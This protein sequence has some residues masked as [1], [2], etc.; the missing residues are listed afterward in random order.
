M[1]ATSSERRSPADARGFTLPE[2]IALLVVIG[3]LAA[4]A[5]PKL[6]LG[7]PLRDEAWRDEVLAALRL[8][9]QTAVSHRRLVCVE[10]ATDRVALRIAATHPASACTTALRGPDGGDDF[11]RAPEGSTVTASPAGPL[12]F[13]PSGRVTSDGAGSTAADLSLTFSGGAAAI[14]IVGET[15][16]VR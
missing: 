16:H 2:L 13:Q 15:G 3:V 1:C 4:V 14:G 9:R 10:V 12:Y 6:D 8:A 11:A 5:L 7:R